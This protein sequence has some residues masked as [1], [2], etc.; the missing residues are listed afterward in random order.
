MRVSKK[1]VA[2]LSVSLGLLVFFLPFRR[3]PTHQLNIKTYFQNAQ[4]LQRGAPVLIDGVQVGSV[5]TVAV[6][7]ELKEHPVEVNLAISTPYVL[8]IPNDSVIGIFTQGVLGP[9]AVEIDTRLRTGSPI[10]NNAI[11]KSVE[12]N[13]NL[14]ADAMERLGN[15]ASKR[16][17]EP[18]RSPSLPSTK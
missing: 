14:Q 18:D 3:T 13:G 16:L 6:R 7:P 12:V 9:P 17:R 2:L 8:A 1:L 10:G 4:N 11:L 15:M 5:T